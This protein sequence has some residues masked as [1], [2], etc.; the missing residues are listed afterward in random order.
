MNLHGSLASPYVARVVL[1]A[2]LKGITLAPRMPEGGIKSPGYL[3]R[4]PMGK[5]PALEVDG[6]VIPESEVICEYLED[7]QPGTGGL[8]GDPME[9]AR[10]RLISRIH[11]VYVSPHS[12]VLFRNLNPAKRDEAAVATAKA[13][14]ET[15]FGYLA[16]FITASPFAAGSRLSLA[17]CTLLPSFAIKRKTA[18]PAFGV[19]DPTAGQGTLGRW[20]SACEADP[21]A[22]PF[23]E[24][25]SA[26]VDAFLRMLA[27]K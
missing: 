18:F 24:E 12:S 11:D 15:G 21:V 3:A 13:S 2:R 1:F 5:M 14:I 25:Y 4:N 19:P 22:G 26:A 27:G 7:L 23:L 6:T 8:V 16:H 10:A 9:R 17:D 20:W